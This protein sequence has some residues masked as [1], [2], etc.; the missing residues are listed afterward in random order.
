[1]LKI[2]NDELL[3]KLNEKSKINDEPDKNKKTDKKYKSKIPQILRMMVWDKYIGENVGKSKCKCCETAE[4]TQMKFDCGHIIAEKNGGKLHIDNMI[5]ICS[6][7]NNSM[8]IQN[9][10][11]FKRKINEFIK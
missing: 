2:K 10:H 8:G 4:I 6:M 3:K 5:P 7:C 1:M 9:Y 11:D